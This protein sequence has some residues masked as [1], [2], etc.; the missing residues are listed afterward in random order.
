[1]S[2]DGDAAGTARPRDLRLPG[3]VV[4][5]RAGDPRPEVVVL[6]VDEAAALLNGPQGE[7]MHE[8]I[9]AIAGAGRKTDLEPVQPRPGRRQA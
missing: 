3:A 8:L 6:V 9:A 1:M 7:E 5:A 2:A 4:P